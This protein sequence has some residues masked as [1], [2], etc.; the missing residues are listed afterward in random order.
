MLTRF[1]G[2]I[3]HVIDEGTPVD[4]AEKAVEPLGL[5]MPPLVLLE[6]VGPAVAPARPETLQPRPSRTASRSRGTWRRS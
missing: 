5:P 3:Q 4:V 1:M 2:E 6:L